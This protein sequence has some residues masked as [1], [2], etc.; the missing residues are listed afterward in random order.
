MPESTESV[1][2]L[3]QS[4]ADKLIPYGK[5]KFE[6]LEENKRRR[7][8][9]RAI[10]DTAD[11]RE[12]NLK[13]WDVN[14]YRRFMVEEVAMEHERL[15]EYFPL[16]YTVG[17]M[18]AYSLITSSCVLLQSRTRNWWDQGGMEM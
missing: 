7:L 4:L 14:Y 5:R 3:L 18:L 6:L 11:S 15:A 2:N 1:D 16:R 8:C 10:S 9:E 17:I 12:I 13:S